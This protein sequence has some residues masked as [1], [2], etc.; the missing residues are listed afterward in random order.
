MMQRLTQKDNSGKWSLKG[1][2]WEKLH[3]GQCITDEIRERLYGA[4]FKL[5]RYEDTGLAPD[6]IV[7]LNNFEKSQTAHLLKELGKEKKKHAWIPVE[8]RLPEA[9]E[10]VLVSFENFSLPMIGRYTV[11]NDDGGTFRIG[12]DDDSFVQ[13]DL[14]VN[15]WMYPP[16]PY[17]ERNK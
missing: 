6:E 1:V 5:M 14:F 10:Y 8:E 15:A 11:D 4:L 9:D 13:H 3:A 16:E 12:D 17:G 7:D 2:P